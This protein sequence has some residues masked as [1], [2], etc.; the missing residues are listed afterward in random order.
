MFGAVCSSSSSADGLD[1]H[2]NLKVSIQLLQTK[3]NIWM[4]FY[5][6]N[7]LSK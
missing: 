4:R 5:T 3:P 6:L 7:F 2:I 1:I